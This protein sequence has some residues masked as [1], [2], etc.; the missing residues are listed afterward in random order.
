[1]KLEEP[2]EIKENDFN[3]HNED[4]EDMVIPKPEHS[5]KTEELNKGN[6]LNC[7]F[8]D[9]LDEDNLMMKDLEKI[10]ELIETNMLKKG[11]EIQISQE[12]IKD[13][14]DELKANKNQIY[15]IKCLEFSHDGSYLFIF[16]NGNPYIF[17]YNLKESK[18]ESGVFKFYNKSTFY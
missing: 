15:S 6:I 1:M 18:I 3:Y 4:L 10:P 12:F 8:E 5:I 2:K 14:L 11:P 17:C 13:F 9:N 7:K 16:G